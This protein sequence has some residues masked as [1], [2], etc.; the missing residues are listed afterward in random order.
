MEKIRFHLPGLR[1]NY[2]VNM[3][4][5]SMMEQYPDFFYEN[6][7]IGSFYGEFPTSLWGGGR[8][9]NGDQCGSAFIRYVIKN[10]NAHGIPVRYTFTNPGLRQKDMRDE[11]CNFCMDAADN[12]MNE[13][14]V[15]SPVL[16][17]YIR[18]KYPKFKINSSTCKEIKD[19]DALN[20][21]LAKDYALVV[22]DYNL[23]NQWDFLEKIEDKERCELLINACCVPNCPRRGDHYKC[24]GEQQRIVL[25]NRKLP[26]N[27]QKPVPGWFC[28]YGDKNSLYTIQNYPTFISPEAIFEK[29]VPMGFRNFKIEGRTGNVF[30]L[31]D[32]YCLW[33]MKPEKR[34]EGRFMLITNLQGAKIITVNHPRPEKWP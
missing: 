23:N 9:C 25:S 8:F 15:V 17:E 3:F 1:Y 2:P 31:I 16:E 6:V 24:I 21:E 5:V 34:D 19:I 28:E 32:Q 26:Q 10:I 22:L 27:M 18:K 30:N 4:L 20:A 13:V 11:Y 29:Y 33:M 14:L 12:G 7:E